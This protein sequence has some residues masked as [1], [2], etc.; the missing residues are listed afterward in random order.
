[1]DRKAVDGALKVNNFSRDALRM[2]DSA[3]AEKYGVCARQ[4][5]NWRK[6]LGITRRFGAIDHDKMRQ[7]IL[8]GTPREQIMKQLGCCKSAVNDMKR[9]MGLGR[10]PGRH[11]EKKQADP[12]YETKEEI[13]PPADRERLLLERKLADFS[14]AHRAAFLGGVA[15]KQTMEGL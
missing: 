12:I 14:P 2:K 10:G 11:T 6:K 4:I 9:K 5:E 3:L 7:L 13:I 1:M 8:A 15:F